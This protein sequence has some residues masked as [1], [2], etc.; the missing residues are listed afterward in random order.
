MKTSA[1]LTAA[2][3][4]LIVLCLLM[5]GCAA[6]PSG[7]TWWNPATWFSGSEG[8][9]VEQAS[10]AQIEARNAVIKAA[11]KT[12]HETAGHL[13]LAPVSRPVELAT[14]ANGV[15]VSLLDQ[16]A[17]PLTVEESNRIRAQV[18]A[19]NSELAVVRADAERQR[20]ADRGQI[21]DVSAQLGAATA[22]LAAAQGD[23]AAG[24]ARENAL[25]NQ[26]RNANLIKW[27]GIALSTLAT[28]AAIAYRSNALG[29]ADGVA[30]GLADL[31]KKDSGSAELA[32]AALDAGLNRSEQST[33]ARLVQAHLA[34]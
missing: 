9:R 19:L 17:G 6:R 27:G 15:T 4:I 28:L 33:L 18:A 22:K 7:G 2:W 32:T 5:P 8:R 25:A 30:R 10:T 1:Q 21:A 13:A 24:F 14:E 20:A 31:R 26:L 16:A 3:I 11:Q 34:R 23:L 12:A 29:L